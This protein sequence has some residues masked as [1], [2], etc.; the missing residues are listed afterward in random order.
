[1]KFESFLILHRQEGSYHGQGTETYSKY[2][3][4]RKENKNNDVGHGTLNNGGE[5]EII[6]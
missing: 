6:E 4:M 5:E 2:F 1:M 3:L